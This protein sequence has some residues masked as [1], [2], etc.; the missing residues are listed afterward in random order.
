M[1]TALNDDATLTL[2]DRVY[3]EVCQVPSSDFGYYFR[4]LYQ[5]P[6]FIDQSKVTD[7]Q[8]YAHLL[9][10]QLS[11]AELTLLFYNC[12]SSVGRMQFKPLAEKYAL[13]EGMRSTQ[14]IVEGHKRFYAPN[15][16]GLRSPS[17]RESMA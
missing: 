12:L 10:A 1:Q 8:R 16:Y 2:I 3:K 7:P 13:F 4:N 14:S 6:K 5:I 15:A 17:Q 9:R 11:T